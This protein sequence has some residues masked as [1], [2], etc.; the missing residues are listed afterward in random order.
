MTYNEFKFCCLM[1]TKAFE[2]KKYEEVVKECYSMDKDCII[3]FGKLVYFN[4][5]FG[6][7]SRKYLFEFIIEIL[8]VHN[9]NT[10]SYIFNSMKDFLDHFKISLKDIV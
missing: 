9:Y 5:C 8:I 2:G 10:S 4:N 7:N 1:F 3:S 6:Y